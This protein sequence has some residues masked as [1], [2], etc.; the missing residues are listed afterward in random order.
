[1]VRLS[2]CV[3]RSPVSGKV[4]GQPGFVESALRTTH[5]SRL[6][7]GFRGLVSHFTLV[8]DER[9]ALNRIVE[10]EVKRP[11]LDELSDKV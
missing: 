10:V 2:G 11:F 9:A 7:R 4:K 1:M 3:F 6:D 8:G 5:G